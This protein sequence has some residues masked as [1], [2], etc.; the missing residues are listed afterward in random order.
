[1]SLCCYI[2]KPELINDVSMGFIS[3]LIQIESVNISLDVSLELL[4][5]VSD[6][7]DAINSRLDSLINA[8]YREALLY[9]REGNFDKY[10]ECIVQATAVDQLNIL[11]Q[12][13]YIKILAN[14]K[15]YTNVVEQY[16]DIMNKFGVL[17]EIVPRELIDAY[18]KANFNNIEKKDFS[19]EIDPTDTDGKFDVAEI[20]ASRNIFVVKW[21]R[22]KTAWFLFS[23]NHFERCCVECYNIENTHL[24]GFLDKTVE[25]LSVTNQFVFLKVDNN[26]R[27]FDYNGREIDNGLLNIIYEKVLS[28]S[29]SYNRFIIPSKES[30]TIGNIN[31]QRILSSKEV[32]V[33]NENDVQTYTIYFESVRIDAKEAT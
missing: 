1:M 29:I 33:Y 4:E 22:P 25:V 30:K 27:C 23:K 19:I 31:I 24:F 26:L 16:W 2:I 11:A 9:E 13:A 15:K 10:R 8:A 17:D 18:T 14:E 28:K 32:T 7:I 6:N 3:N 20:W 12:L 5:S 21:I